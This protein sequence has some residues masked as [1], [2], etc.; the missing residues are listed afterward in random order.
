MFPDHTVQI[1]RVSDPKTGR[2][3]TRVEQKW[4]VTKELGWGSF[5]V[6]NLQTCTSGPA[7]GQLRA[8]KQIRKGPA[9][10]DR[11]LE[12]IAKFSQEKVTR[13]SRS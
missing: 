13:V 6:V 8:V 7:S 1:V 12:A 4:E 9:N 10:Y 5:G 2:R 3:P 11:E